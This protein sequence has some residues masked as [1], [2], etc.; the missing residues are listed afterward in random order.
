MS[1][2]WFWI[3]YHSDTLSNFMMEHTNNFL[4]HLLIK[5]IISKSEKFKVLKKTW[6]KTVYP[7]ICAFHFISNLIQIKIEC[8]KLSEIISYTVQI[9]A[10]KDN[11]HL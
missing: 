1:S 3:A 7:Y 2:M 5:Q 10:T 8:N 4:R 6:K 9:F 11:E